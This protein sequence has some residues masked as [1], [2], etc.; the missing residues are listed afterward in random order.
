VQ[1]H[2]DF[3][4]VI[5]SPDDGP[6]MWLTYNNIKYTVVLDSNLNANVWIIDNTKERI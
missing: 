5:Q 6:K 1:I 3:K 4:F 2:G